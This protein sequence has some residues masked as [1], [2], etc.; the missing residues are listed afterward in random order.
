MTDDG[1]SRTDASDDEDVEVVLKPLSHDLRE[2]IRS[3]R[4]RIS[5]VKRNKILNENDVQHQK[6]KDLDDVAKNLGD[7]ISDYRKKT[8]KKSQK[9]I[10]VT[11][12]KS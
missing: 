3:I 1:T 10:P 11:F 9:G 4:Y 5:A 2:V 12:P 7:A 6:L 8:T